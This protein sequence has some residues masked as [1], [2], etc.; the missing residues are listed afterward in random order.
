MRGCQ[1]DLDHPK[2]A[3]FAGGV[4]GVTG[5]QQYSRSE[6]KGQILTCGIV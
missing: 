4:G 6:V 2:R 1:L 5:Q 3:D